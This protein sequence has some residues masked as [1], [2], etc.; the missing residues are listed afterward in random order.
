MS[1]AALLVMDSLGVGGAEDAAAFGDAGADTF[2][3][4]VEACALGRGNRDG[5]RRGPLNIPF[6]IAHGLGLATEASRGHELTG[7]SKPPHQQGLWGFAREVSKG[8]DTPSGH[9]E[10]AGAPVD[11]A[12]GYFPN[13]Q[14]SFPPELTQA[15]I[16]QGGLPGILGDCHASGTEIIEDLGLEHMRTGKPIVYTSVDS[17]LQIAAHEESFGLERLYE[18]CRIARKLCDPLKIGRIIARPFVGDAPGAFKRT[19]R[20]KD[21]AMPPA[22][23]NLLDRAAEANRPVISIGKIG[24][25]FAHRNTGEEI[26]GAGDM[27]LFDKTIE[28]FDRLPDGG[29]L[30]ANYLDLDTEFGHRRDVAGAA[31]CLEALDRRMAELE[32]RLRPGDLV[33]FTGDHGNDPTWR[34]T[35]HTRENVPILAFGQGLAGGPLGARS[36][37]ADMGASIAA[38]LGLGATSA[39]R[40]WW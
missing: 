24:D 8:K 12:W 10:I 2:G 15:L 16:A 40:P 18:L 25:I 22:M 13:T 31:A 7:L 14:P 20:R 19:P 11:F 1:R 29:L 23:G 36:T 32:A 9:W 17:V 35:D 34:G 28:A 26:K 3:H 30:F 6:L 4:I 27:D 5:L 38:Y 37:F 39:G 21:F 33:I